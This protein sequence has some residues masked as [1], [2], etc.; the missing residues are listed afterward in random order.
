MSEVESLEEGVMYVCRVTAWAEKY[1]S[2]VAEI[3]ITTNERSKKRYRYIVIIYISH[4]LY[5][6]LAHML[7]STA[8][9]WV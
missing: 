9:T 1:S 4:F 6:R 8:C 7:R 5:L 3:S 2:E